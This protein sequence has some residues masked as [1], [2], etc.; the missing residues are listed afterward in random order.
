[1]ISVQKVLVPNYIII[2][3]DFVRL[4]QKIIEVFG[5]IIPPIAAVMYK[6][7]IKKMFLVQKRFKSISLFETNFVESY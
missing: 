2:V 3:N 5:V 6:L 7:I 1:M 4:K